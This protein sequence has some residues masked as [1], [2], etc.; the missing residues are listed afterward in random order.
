V[1]ADREP[2]AA[3]RRWWRARKENR[4]LAH[5]LWVWQRKHLDDYYR[6]YTPEP[7]EFEARSDM[8]DWAGW[9]VV[10][11]SWQADETGRCL[12]TH[13][14]DERRFAEYLEADRG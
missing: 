13:S 12:A 3:I 6:R 1:A 11:Q 9:C 7:C 10:H 5:H 2:A 4:E 14:E 8:G